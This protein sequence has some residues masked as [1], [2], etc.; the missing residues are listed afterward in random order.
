MTRSKL[1][2]ALLEFMRPFSFRLI[3]PVMLLLG[4][5]AVS[6]LSA[7]RREWATL[8][9]CQ[10]IASEYNDGDSFHIRG[11]TNDFFVRLY[12]VDAPETNLRYAER[13]REQAEYFGV[14]LDET[15][16]AGA[17]AREAVRELLREPFV[18]QTRW[19]SAAGRTKTPRYYAF[20]QAGGTNLAEVLVARGLARTKGVTAALPDGEK[21][22]VFA[23]KLQALEGEARQKR[24]GVWAAAVGRK[25]EATTP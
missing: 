9:N 4:G 18:V 23:G 2:P 8:T 11:G 16:K 13:T 17:Q 15:L 24:L 6:G 19:A 7:E 20:V 22:K 12:F 25:P 21:S 5:A 14:T 1:I 10:L 3:L